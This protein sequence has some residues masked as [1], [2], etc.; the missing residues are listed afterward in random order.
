MGTDVGSL[1]SC[2][3]F[4]AVSNDVLVL[5]PPLAVKII[6]TQSVV[7]CLDRFA[8]CVVVVVRPTYVHASNNMFTFIALLLLS[9]LNVRPAGNQAVVAVSVYG[10]QRK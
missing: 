3:G 1:R 9:R 6:Q 5:G 10:R 7:T 2:P 4:S 8:R